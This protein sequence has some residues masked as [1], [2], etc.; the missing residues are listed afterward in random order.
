VGLR[1]EVGE[2]RATRCVVEA[3]RTAVKLH[4]GP[5]GGGPGGWPWRHGLKLLAAPAGTWVACAVQSEQVG[6]RSTPP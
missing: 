1:L 4:A 6:S 3:V 2:Q 5:G